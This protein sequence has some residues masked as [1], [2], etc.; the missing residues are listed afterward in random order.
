ME[1]PSAHGWGHCPACSRAPGQPW[2]QGLLRAGT[3]GVGCSTSGDTLASS[4]T[5]CMRRYVADRGGDSKTSSGMEYVSSCMSIWKGDGLSPWIWVMG[6]KLTE[7][8]PPDSASP[9]LGR[10]GDPQ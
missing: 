6:Q 2:G 10:V 5:W 7:P 9:W 1:V 3:H 4:A 8:T